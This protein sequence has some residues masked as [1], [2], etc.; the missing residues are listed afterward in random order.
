MQLPLGRS[1]SELE[2]IRA[3]W[4]QYE[5]ELEKLEFNA[6]FSSLNNRWHRDVLSGPISYLVSFPLSKVL[7]LMSLCYPG[8][9]LYASGTFT[10]SILSTFIHRESQ[11]Y[12]YWARMP[13]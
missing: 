12:L 1:K 3:K 10:S 8:F 4:N 11:P 7:V 5:D 2:G 6:L 13:D 9:P